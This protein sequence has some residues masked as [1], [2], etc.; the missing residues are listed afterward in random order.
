MQ[1][2]YIQ[3][4]YTSI[5]YP[6]YMHT[7]HIKDTYTN[8]SYTQYIYTRFIAKLHIQAIHI[9]VFFLHN[10]YK[11]MNMAIIII[12][13]IN[14]TN[15]LPPAMSVIVYLYFTR[16]CLESL[17]HRNIIF[18]YTQAFILAS[19]KTLYTVKYYYSHVLL[20]KTDPENT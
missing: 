3:D 11:H 8:M 1:H 4:T 18:L 9:S 6:S 16:S 20:N 15:P 19:Y 2:T 17:K 7:F 5:S 10:R 12:W 13:I 14:H